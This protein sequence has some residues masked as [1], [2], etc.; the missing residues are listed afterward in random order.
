MEKVHKKRL[1]YRV[2]SIIDSQ[3]IITKAKKLLM[4]VKFKNQS[5]F[6]PRYLLDL[7]ELVVHNGL[8]TQHQQHQHF[9]SD[10]PIRKRTQSFKNSNNSSR[11]LKE[12]DC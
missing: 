5:Y 11:I 1:I 10:H 3:E 9:S 4:K 8:R 6:Q 7:Q 12:D 2:V